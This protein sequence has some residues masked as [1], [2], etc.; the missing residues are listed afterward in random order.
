MIPIPLN[1]KTPHLLQ[2]LLMYR[3]KL[4]VRYAGA[5]AAAVFSE[6]D[7]QVREGFMLWM[8]DK[9]TDAFQAGGYTLGSIIANTGA[10]QA[11][12]LCMMDTFAR[13]PEQKKNVKWIQ[14]KEKLDVQI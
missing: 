13:H 4:P 11:E 14:K 6:F 5:L 1:E 2:Q 3:E 10:T 12:A 7:E 9:L 8:D